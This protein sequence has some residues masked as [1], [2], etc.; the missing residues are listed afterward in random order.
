[1]T[2]KIYAAFS[3]HLKNGNRLSLLYIIKDVNT[4]EIFKLQASKKDRFRKDIAWNL[5]E[6]YFRKGQEAFNFLFP[7]YHPEIIQINYLDNPHKAFK[8]YCLENFYKKISLLSSD[9]HVKV[10]DY[11]YRGDK[12]FRISKYRII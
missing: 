5:A 7:E 1:M 6:Y 11:V 2:D 9:C 12:K 8:E 10:A 4:I 3:F